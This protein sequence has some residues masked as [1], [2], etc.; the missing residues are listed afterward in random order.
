MESPACN[1][2]GEPK[3]EVKNMVRLKIGYVSTSQLSFPGDKQSA[4]HASVEGLKKL[5]QQ[6]DFD[7]YVYEKTVITEQDALDAR[8]VLQAEHVDLIMLQCTSFAA[9]LVV[10]TL[11]RTK[12]ARLGLWAIPEMRGRG[13]VSYNSLCGINMYSAIV[14]H[15][16]KEYN[17]A[18]KWFYG[19][20]EYVYTKGIMSG[21]GATIFDP[22]SQLTRGMI[23]T[24]LYRMEKEP[25]VSGASKFT[26]VDIALWYGKAVV[27]AADN[28][29][30]TG[31]SDTAF[32]P[33]DPVTREQLAAIL[34]RYAVYRGMTAVTLEDNL[35]GFADADQ[36]SSYAISA[37]NWAVG[38]GLINGS[39]STLAPKAQATRAQ[40]AAIIH[41]YLEG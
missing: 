34:Y 20:V 23:V 6:W 1:T 29:I 32:G 7:L 10:S 39:G 8:E 38:K 37:M 27:W 22:N 36:I 35:G 19:D 40:V 41:R 5:A 33:N 11:A 26:D 12:G 13:V 24:I 30:V 28:G 16:L 25:A 3:M 21:T 18:T 4:V 9:G 2:E 15:Y 14:A 31:Y 17:I